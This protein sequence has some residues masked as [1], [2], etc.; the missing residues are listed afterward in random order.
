MLA[1]QN[2]MKYLLLVTAAALVLGAC[3]KEEVTID[4]PIPAPITQPVDTV[5][6][7][8]DPPDE[9]CTSPLTGEWT[10]IEWEI[11]GGVGDSFYYQ[12]FLQVMDTII[13]VTDLNLNPGYDYAYATFDQFGFGT[14]EVEWFQNG[15]PYSYDFEYDYDCDTEEFDMDVNLEAFET[16]EYWFE[17]GSPFVTV[18][19]WSDNGAEFYMILHRE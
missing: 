4:D 5:E 18:T 8:V 11:V 15:I 7:I 1:K 17:N 6:V 2:N 10:L 13:S 19:Y 3:T 9:D 14:F 12:P 16:T